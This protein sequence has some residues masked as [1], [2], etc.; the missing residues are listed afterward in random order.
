MLWISRR[1]LSLICIGY[2]IGSLLYLAGTQW[3]KLSESCCEEFFEGEE[4]P[5]NADLYSGS[6]Y[7]RGQPTESM[8]RTFPRVYSTS[9]RKL[10]ALQKTC[11]TTCDTLH[12]GRRPGI[13]RYFTVDDYRV[14]NHAYHYS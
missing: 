4:G 12:P 10:T 13:V 11:Y 6:H 14:P 3:L 5:N 2:S 9:T 8:F 1:V 7:V